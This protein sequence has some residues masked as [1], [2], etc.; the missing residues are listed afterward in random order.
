MASEDPAW[1]HTR[2]FRESAEEGD[3][4]KRQVGGGKIVDLHAAHHCRP[5]I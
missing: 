3:E 4:L 2:E 5:E 1:G